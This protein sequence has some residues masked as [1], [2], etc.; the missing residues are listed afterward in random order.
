MDAPVTSLLI[1]G[2][3]MSSIFA[4]D[5]LEIETEEESGV[6]GHRGAVALWRRGDDHVLVS[7]GRRHLY[8]GWTTRDVVSIVGQAWERGARRMVVTNAA[9]G[10][11]PRFSAGDLMLIDDIIPT[12]GS[13]VA[14]LASRSRG[15]NPRDTLDADLC[16]EVEMRCTSAGVAV[17]RGVYAM[18][19]G[20]SY[21]TRAEI[22]M[23]R[24][25]GAD[26]VG[27]S[28]APEVLAARDLGMRSIGLS[29]ITNVATD[30]S[31]RG[32][33]SHDEVLGVVHRRMPVLRAAIEVALSA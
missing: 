14:G 21:E 10:L 20:P 3:G 27:M 17:K 15:S 13:N 29:M 26:A 8:Q 18:M 16:R 11:N 12:P 1:L 32:V 2:S 24:T 23:L 25:M 7:V 30:V 9:G 19:I 6:P 33:L 31:H 22:R 5:E 4:T 28:T